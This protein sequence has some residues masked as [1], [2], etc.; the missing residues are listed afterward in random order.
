MR[1]ENAILSEQVFIAQQQFLVD[2]SRDEGEQARP[3]QLITH[4]K[5][6][7]TPCLKGVASVRRVF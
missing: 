1:A 2:Q 3:M 6:H 4:E 5:V 7:H